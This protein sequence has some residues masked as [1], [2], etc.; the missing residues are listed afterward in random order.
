MRRDAWIMWDFG[1][2]GSNS[3]SFFLLQLF[4]VL[5]WVGVG[6]LEFSRA[7]SE[8]LL[9]L[10]STMGDDDDFGLRNFPSARAL[11]SASDVDMSGLPIDID[12]ESLLLSLLSELLELLL[13]PN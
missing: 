11:A 7:E 12:N 9:L 2:G 1:G 4:F 5:L 13:R 6:I 3:F 10:M 8:V